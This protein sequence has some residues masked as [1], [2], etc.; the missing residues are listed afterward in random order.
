M[1]G[2]P[3]LASIITVMI[4]FVVIIAIEWRVVAMLYASRERSAK[5]C[6]VTFIK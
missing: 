6:R 4:E 2:F 1:P 5:A 3:L